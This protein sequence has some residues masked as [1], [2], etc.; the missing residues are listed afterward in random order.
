MELLKIVLLFNIYLHFII[1]TIYCSL[2][3]VRLLL[4]MA[5]RDLFTS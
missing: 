1:F 5:S 3:T 4:K 2:S